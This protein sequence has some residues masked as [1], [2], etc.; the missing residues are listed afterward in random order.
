[1]GFLDFLFR[2]RSASPP[3]GNKNEVV[4]WSYAAAQKAA[5]GSVGVYEN[6]SITTRGEPTG[7]DFAS[8]LLNPQKNIYDLYALSNYYKDADPYVGASI[9]N[10]YVPFSIARGWK[11]TGAAKETKKK[12]TDHYD[13]IGFEG[14]LG[15]I[16]DQ[17]FTFGNVFI[18]LMPDGSISTLI[19]SRCRVSE[20]F[21]DGE[22]IVEYDTQDIL[23]GVQGELAARED[24][25]DDLK[26]R[27]KGLPKEIVDN[28]I[29]ANGTPNPARKQWVQLNPYNT[30]VLQSP[31]PDWAR[32]SVPVVARCLTA[33]SRKA[34]ISD[35]EKAQ[36][37]YGIKGFLHVKVGD[38]DSTSGMTTPN[39]EHIAQIYSSFDQGL[40][41]GKQVVTPWY[42][43]AK[44]ITV[45]TKSLFDN[46]KY[47]GVN[48]EILSAFGISGV[49]SLGQQE[50]GSYGQ[51]KLSLETA[52]LRIEQAQKNF[53]AMMQKINIRLAERI[54]RIASKNIPKFEFNA[55]DL[56]NDGKFAEAVYKLWQQGVTSNQ[57]L[58]ESYHLDIAQEEE[59]RKEEKKNGMDQLFLPRQTS[60][61]MS[62]PSDAN[63]TGGRPEMD[64][65]DRSSDP[66][67]S[68]TGKQPKPSNPDGSD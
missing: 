16:F 18:Y 4:E 47:S 6:K 58:L 50:A 60:Y 65:G 53:A 48:Q 37:R 68:E 10:V 20:V 41:G 39:S 54:P 11:L 57:T 55:V 62:A 23:K 15:S 42:V 27:T 49:I 25:L 9:T 56:A 13:K 38:K 1:M 5:E 28:L 19:P 61:T 51:A 24:F 31:K 64:D 22:P 7:Y 46:D 26:A 43:D 36:L 40:R 2:N 8:I 35:Y 33:L 17:Y 34:L 52:A 67:K 66:E 21:M 45:D 32:Y 59:R 63:E 44:F 3:A 14:K 30:F 29:L 12:F